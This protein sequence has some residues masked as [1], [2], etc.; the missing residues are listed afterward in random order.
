MVH[1]NGAAIAARS[2]ADPVAVAIA[3]Q[4]PLTE[5]AEVRFILPMKRIAGRTKAMRQ[6]F[7]F[8]QRHSMERWAYFFIGI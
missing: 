2:I 8:P 6:I 3:L 4:H 1:G 5:A 7:A